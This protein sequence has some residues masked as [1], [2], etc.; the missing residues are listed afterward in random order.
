MTKLKAVYIEWVDHSSQNGWTH[1]D[2]IMT[3]SF[4][5]R[6]IVVLVREDDK[7]VTITDTFSN[8][9]NTRSP[10]TILKKNILKRR[11]VKLPLV[12]SK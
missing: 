11:N 7:S 5:C 12:S 2:D 9:Y 4:F 10:L 1:I 6:S 8:N 3:G